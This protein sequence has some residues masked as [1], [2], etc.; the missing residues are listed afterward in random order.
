MANEA[1]VD[2]TTEQSAKEK[3]SNKADTS[4]LVLQGARIKVTESGYVPG[5]T[6]PAEQ[7]Q[8]EALANVLEN[9]ALFG[10]I[11]L[12]LP[13]ITYKVYSKS[14]EWDL[15]A[16]WSVSFCSETQ[17]YDETD[18]KL[19]HLMAQELRLVPRDPNYINPYRN[20]PQKE[21]LKNAK[22]KEEATSKK[23]QKKKD[24]KKRGP[25]LSH[26]EL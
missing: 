6:F 19:L 10:D 17:V 14:K 7:S 18:T 26:A 1:S 2:N 4:M 25:R 23:N 13:D 24:K 11:L 16:R 15:L 12:R 20:V 22:S 9:T 5:Q 3:S 21:D 8:R